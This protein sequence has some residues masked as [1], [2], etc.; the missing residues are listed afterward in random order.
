M[1]RDSPASHRNREPILGLLR[2]IL[3]ARGT[4]LEIAS[5]AGQHAVWFAGVL[6]G[7]VWQP[8]D[9]EPDAIVSI[10]AWRTDSGLPNLRP[11]VQ[12]DVREDWPP[13]QADVIVCINMVH[14]SPWAATLGLL[15][16]AA[17]VLPT[18]GA[19][20]MYGA[21]RENGVTA[22]SNEAFEREFLQ[23][24]DPTWGLRDTVDVIAR[25]EEVGLRW[26]RTVTMPANN[27]TLVLR[28]A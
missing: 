11:A 26:D 24:R 8:T 5:G 13:L 27:R 20:L 18:G 16:G 12:L 9:A 22:P 1:K 7:I 28:R 19:L 4:V 21:W 10:D 2:E 25:G 17:Q 23:V 6:P 14:A 15:A 3:P